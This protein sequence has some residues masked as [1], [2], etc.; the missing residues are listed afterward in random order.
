M[1]YCFHNVLQGYPDGARSKVML[2]AAC[3][4]A[5]VVIAIAG[6]GKGSGHPAVYPVSGQVLWNGKP[7]AGALVVLHPQVTSDARCIPARAHTDAKGQFRAGTFDSADG[8][9][10][11]EYAVTVTYCPLQKND[12][13]WTPGPNVLPVKYASPKTT[14]LRVQVAKGTN[15]LP[16]LTVQQ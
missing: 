4:A 15:S 8:A 2:S 1:N 10:E 9:Q 16:P 3:A 7:L 6:C 11:G 12:D 14:D 5:I 13:G